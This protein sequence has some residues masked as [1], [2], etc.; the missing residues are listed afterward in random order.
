M[1]VEQR[2]GRIDRIGQTYE[3]VWVRNYFY[4]RTVEADI[5]HRLDDRIGSFEHVVGEL[6]P[7]LARVGRVIEAAAMTGEERREQLIAQE[8]ES[9]NQAVRS[10]EAGLLNL[11]RLTDDEVAAPAGLPPPLTMPELE[12]TLVG[13]AALHDRFRPHDTIARA[14]LLDWDGQMQAVTFDPAVYDEHPNTV[15]L[16][17]YGGDLLASLLAAV[18]PPHESPQGALVR[19]AAAGPRE[20][21]GWYA[22]RDGSVMP[23]RTLSRLQ[24]ALAQGGTG[25]GAAQGVA[26]AARTSFEQEMAPIREQETATAQAKERSRSEALAEEIRDLLLQAAYVEIARAS[27]D[28]MFSADGPLGFSVETVRRLR[29]H[30]FPFAGAL[31][32]VSVDGLNP[33]EADPKYVKLAQSRADQLDRRF[34]AIKNRLAGLLPDY[35][36]VVETKGQDGPVVSTGHE[37]RVTAFRAV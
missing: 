35:V 4:E 26:A 3:R 24:E 5:Y 23:L 14:H 10:A 16:V 1:R 13:S 22:G 8:V 21:A 20:R 12:R 17:T 25:D 29:R 9:I 30:K 15:R 6:Q 27:A 33:S 2:I 18:D 19:C 31:K 32:A 36:K 7:I 34:E 37:C 11:D 28:G